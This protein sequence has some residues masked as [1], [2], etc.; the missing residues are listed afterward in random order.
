MYILQSYTLDQIKSRMILFIYMLQS[1][2]TVPIISFLLVA[3]PAGEQCG[4]FSSQRAWIFP[5]ELM[6]NKTELKAEWI[7]DPC[8]LKLRV[9]ADVAQCLLDV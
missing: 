1:K 2:Y 8:S 9:K 5:L 3:N 7:L 4:A 6:E